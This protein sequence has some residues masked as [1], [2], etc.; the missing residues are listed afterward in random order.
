MKERKTISIFIVPDDGSGPKVWKLGWPTYRFLKVALFVFVAVVVVGSVSYWRVAR[1]ATRARAL[2]DKNELLELQIRK[3]GEL[4]R[5]FADIQATDRQ[6]RTMLGMGVQDS[7]APSMSR[8]DLL[9]PATGPMGGGAGRRDL[10]GSLSRFIPSGRP[11]DGWITAGFEGKSTPSKERHEGIDIAAPKGSLVKAAADGTVLFAGWDDDLG[12]LVA[13]DHGGYF[14][15]RYGHNSK[16]LVRK[17]DRVW[18]GQAIALVGSTGR[19]TAPHLHFEVLEKGH[20][21]DPTKFLI[22]K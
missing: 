2:Q 10:S 13:I 19:S 5:T 17:G 1:L 22:A 12:N 16:V 9:V 6:L 14:V 8:T 20:P 11:V 15:T 21:K 18:K 3:I 4:R 7:T